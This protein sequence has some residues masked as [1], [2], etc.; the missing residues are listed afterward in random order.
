MESFIV[1]QA[2]VGGEL[3]PRP[4]Y[5]LLLESLS[6]EVVLGDL[7]RRVDWRDQE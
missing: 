5:P 1:P 6:W 4:R 7:Q 3:E 2:D